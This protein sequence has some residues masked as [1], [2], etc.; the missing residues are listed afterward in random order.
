MRTRFFFYLL[1]NFIVIILTT[2]DAMAHK[3]SAA[4]MIVYLNTEEERNFRVSVQMEVESS[5]DPALDDEVSPEDAGRAFVENNLSVLIDEKEQARQLT[6][7]IVNQSDPETPAE[8]QR[9]SVLVNW[10]GELPKDGKSFSIY[11][12]P[13]SE[14]SIV[15]VTVKNGVPARRLQ[16]IYADEYS[17]SENIEPI[18]KGNP[19]DQPSGETSPPVSKAGESPVQRGSDGF[20]KF[21]KLGA[22]FSLYKTFLPLAFLFSLILLR[23]SLKSLF[24]PLSWFLVAH[25][26]G[27]SLAAMG[28]LPL[29]HGSLPICS[30]LM[31]L[32]SIDNL[33]SFKFRWWRFAVAAI[34]GFFLGM[35]IVQS[36][37]F[38]QLG[39][40]PVTLKFLIPFQLGLIGVF[41]LSSLLFG[42]L[43]N[44]FSRLPFFRK[45]IVVPLSVIIAGVGTF[46]LLA[47]QSG[48]DQWFK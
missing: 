23:G 14:M 18:V 9:L 22:R 32:L 2:R 26:I 37:G 29:F 42:T 8:L 36:S 48:F 10:L 5:G 25:G 20:S 34:G 47:N 35:V 12:K 19:F 11:L 28:L 4:S 31:I 15:M 45:Y 13:T 39:G 46:L 43:A 41:L 38:T 7:E 3:V 17:R 16:A 21:V 44:R 30:F 33:V 24:L 1:I 40:I 6:S 27:I